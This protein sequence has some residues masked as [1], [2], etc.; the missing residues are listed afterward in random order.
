[1]SPLENFTLPWKK[2]CGPPGALYIKIVNQKMKVGETK[3]EQISRT[4]I[5]RPRAAISTEN[6]EGESLDE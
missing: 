6:F 5:E 4:R 2:V 3:F 1:M